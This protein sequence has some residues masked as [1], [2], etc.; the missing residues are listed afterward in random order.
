MRQWTHLKQAPN[1]KIKPNTIESKLRDRLREDWKYTIDDV[2]WDI[3]AALQIMHFLLPAT[4]C[5]LVS[6]DVHGM[7]NTVS[8]GVHDER[9]WLRAINGS[10]DKDD[11][12]DQ[13]VIRDIQ[14]WLDDPNTESELVKNLASSSQYGDVWAL[15]GQGRTTHSS[16]FNVNEYDKILLLCEHV[17]QRALLDEGP[18]AS[19]QSG[20]LGRVLDYVIQHRS[21]QAINLE[22]INKIITNSI[23]FSLMMTSDIWRKLWSSGT[24]FV[25]TSAM[26]SVRTHMRNEIRSTITN[27]ANLTN[28]LTPG[29]S[30]L[31]Y[32]I[33]F[34][35][36]TPEAQ[37]VLAD[38]KSWSWLGPLIHDALKNENTLAAANC[39]VLLGARVS[40]RERM[41]VDT[42][43]LD[44]FFDDDA[45]EVI[46]ILESMIDQLPESDQLLVRNVVGAARQ[47]LAG[48]ALPDEQEGKADAD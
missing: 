19:I 13:E 23:H 3:R 28:I 33:V 36:G 7:G 32:E 24:L 40:G 41:T 9:Y 45:G 22:W 42:E 4:E 39:G 16:I 31:L 10:I 17:I 6:D 35:L 15:L 30:A 27:G 38:A 14:V 2:E 8:Q 48:G 47:H 18:S 26:P 37:K 11:I 5:W 12:L 43:V 46:E 25:C 20:G 21:N 44:E 29:N 34:D 1:S